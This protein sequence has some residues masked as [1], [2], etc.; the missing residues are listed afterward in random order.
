MSTVVL[1]CIGLLVS[2]LIWRISEYRPSVV[3]LVPSSIRISAYVE[4]TFGILTMFCGMFLVAYGNGWL[5]LHPDCA[6][7]VS[8]FGGALWIVL[9]VR[10]SQGSRAARTITLGLSV[11][12]LAT[13]VGIPF[14]LFSLLLLLSK[15]AKTF[16]GSLPDSDQESA[17]GQ[18]L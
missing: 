3:L 11:L 6:F 17:V 9:S 4:A 12:R 18:S 8:F 15:E 14:S 5:A 1:V 2:C 13:V 16:Y 7:A 10:L